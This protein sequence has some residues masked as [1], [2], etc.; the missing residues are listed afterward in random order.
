MTQKL[1]VAAVIPARFASS[2]FPGK[3]LAPLAGK[4]MI[5][6]V[7]ERVKRASRVSEVL[8]ATDDERIRR[9]VVQFGGRAAMTSAD[10]ASGTDRVAE[11]AAGLDADVVVDVQGDEPLIDP[12]VVDQAVEPF[13]DDS[14]LQMSTLGHRIVDPGELQNRDVVKVRIDA[15]GYARDFFRLPEA[16]PD[17]AADRVLKHIGLYAFRRPYLLKLAALEA[18]V[19]ERALGLEQLRALENGCRIK[20]V[21]TEYGS[22][23]IDRPHDLERA[24]MMLSAQKEVPS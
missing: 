11:V 1:S 2:R 22:L 20:V 13:F 12:R 10:H 24:E 14:S 7:Y 3:A 17:G 19:R 21:E 6:H 16:G 15:E 5:Q 18:T 23:G 8:V 9:A 4:P